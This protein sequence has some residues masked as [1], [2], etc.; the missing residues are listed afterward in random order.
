MERKITT[1][2]QY[3]Q[4]MHGICI[5]AVIMIHNSNGQNY[6]VWIVLRQFINFSV[7]MFI[8]LIGYFMTLGKTQGDY[9]NF[10]FKGGGKPICP[11]PSLELYLSI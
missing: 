6:T 4:V 3:C 8:F 9:K 2:F 5:L 10:L 7:A 1:K 11:R